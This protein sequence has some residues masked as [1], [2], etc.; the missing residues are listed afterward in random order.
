MMITASTFSLATWRHSSICSTW[1]ARCWWDTPGAPCSPWTTPP[2]SP[3]VRALRPGLSWWMALSSSWMTSPAP[4]GKAS[5]SAWRRPAWRA[6]PWMP[7]WIA[8]S[9][10]NPRWQPDEQAEQI[11]LANFEIAEDDTIYPRLTFE[12]HMQIV[13][14][15]WEFPTYA[16]FAQVRCPVLA[17]PAQPAPPLSSMEQEYLERKLARRREGAGC[18]PCRAPP[19]DG[20]RHPRHPP[21]DSPRRWPSS[22]WTSSA[23][24]PADANQAEQ[25]GQYIAKGK[26]SPQS[27]RDHRENRN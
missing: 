25:L 23:L 2:A 4:P 9:R 11:I 13:R 21:P 8:Y 3:S 15:M 19:L 7:S 27:H 18:Q 1:N 26:Y 24:F 17:L 10:P 5:A 22:S 16:R 12:R 6:C 14:A 20:E